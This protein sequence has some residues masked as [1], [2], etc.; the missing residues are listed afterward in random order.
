MAVISAN[1]CLGELLSRRI[2]VF[3]SANS[4]MHLG[5][6]SYHSR[7]SSTCGSA[8]TL[9]FI[10]ANSCIHLGELQDFFNVWLGAHPEHY[11]NLPCEWNVRDTLVQMRLT[12]ADD[13]GNKTIWRRCDSPSYE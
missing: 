12:E 4:C 3:I 1:Y 6:F 10:S 2:L 11:Y 9:V 7:I 13:P 5:E 8:R